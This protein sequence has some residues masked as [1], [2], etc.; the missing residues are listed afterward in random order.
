VYL[1]QWHAVLNGVCVCADVRLSIQF[2]TGD[3]S[4]NPNSLNR[5]NASLAIWPMQI[6][7]A[8]ICICVWLCSFKLLSNTFNQLINELTNQRI[9]LCH[10]LN[11]LTNLIKYIQSDQLHMPFSNRVNI[12][13]LWLL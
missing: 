8:C 1:S 7:P 4:L 9:K 13:R 12:V 2:S 10:L 6:L 3:N 5:V 11:S